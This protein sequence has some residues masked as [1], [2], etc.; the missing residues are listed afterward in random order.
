[1]TLTHLLVPVALLEH[2][3]L[4]PQQLYTWQRLRLLA[5]EGLATPELQITRVAG[6]LGC[7]R[8]TL[9]NHLLLLKA[10]GLLS[11]S[12]MPGSRFV[13]SFPAEASPR[14]P[15][16]AQPG[17][18]PTQALPQPT[19][20]RPQGVQESR[21]L[22]SAPS[23][24]ALKDSFLNQES[25]DLRA[26]GFNPQPVPAATGTSPPA[27]DALDYPGPDPAAVF[28]QLTKIAPKPQQRA[29]LRVQVQDLER[30]QAAVE[31][32]LEHNWNPLN[33]AGL[34][35]FYLRGGE[36]SCRACQAAAR[37]SPFSPA[38]PADPLAAVTALRQELEGRDA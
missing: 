8:A 15:E 25:V 37:A 28:R 27:G 6:L 30:W 2:P 7:S 29:M 33:L 14:Q 36:A 35:D 3:G 17:S 34:V 19:A 12:V 4:R 10:L 38:T 20:A 9:Y 26:R 16:M 18:G 1:M 5:G 24:K 23:L 13:F 32:W 31:H 21:N 22:D 11:W